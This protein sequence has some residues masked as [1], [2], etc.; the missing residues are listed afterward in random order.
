MSRLLEDA[1]KAVRRTAD[2][3]AQ[4]ATNER[5]EKVTTPVRRQM[6]S[7]DRERLPDFAEDWETDSGRRNF[8]TTSA[9]GRA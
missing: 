1:T 6:I 8:P 9:T 4:H 2:L 7:T 3:L 5:F